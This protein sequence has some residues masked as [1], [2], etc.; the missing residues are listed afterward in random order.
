VL[1]PRNRRAATALALISCG[2]VAAGC[3][4]SDE[5]DAAGG[6][7]PV[8]KGQALVQLDTQIAPALEPDSAAGSN[9]GFEQAF[10]NLAEPLLSVPTADKDG[11]L[12]PDFAVDQE[13]FAPG[14]AESYSKDGL[15][16]TFNLRQGVK[17]CAG[18][19]LTSADVVYT[20][21]RAKSVTGTAPNSDFVATTGG[22]F[23][24]KE[25]SKGATAADK[26]LDG[27][28]VADGKYKVIFKQHSENELFP[29]ILTIWS[30][31]PWDSVEMKKHATSAD[32]YSHKYVETTDAPAFGPYCLDT[33][34][35][36]SEMTFSANPG[37]YAG[38]PT[39]SKITYKQVPADA[40]RL[41]GI[42]SGDGD[43]ATNL[44]PAQFE[45]VGK[46]PAAS[47][48]RW[49][50]PAN[51]I[52]LGVNYKY[53]PFNDLEKG[54]LLRQAIA[55]ALPYEQIKNDIYYGRFTKADGLVP[56]DSFG[57]KK[58]S[59]YNTD[60]AKAKALMAE[61]GYPNGEGLPADSK[62][63]QISY[64][65]ER[66]AT[67]Q[68]LANLIQTTLKGI[69]FPSKLNP[70]PAAQQETEEYTGRSLGMWLRDNSRAL[71]PDVGYASLLYFVS[72]DGGGLAPATNYAD[73][74]VDELY[75]KSATTTG[76]GRAEALN[77]IQD[78]VMDELPLIPIGSATSQIAVTKGMTGWR[79]NTYDLVYW[80]SLTTS[81]N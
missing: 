3:G 60:L 74:R 57:Y 51:F 78:I 77:E 40:Q 49:D 23:T 39:Y 2:I 38:E 34:K 14:L 67:L 35:K 62:A 11:V 27:E 4:S 15:T 7:T 63:F 22:I 76:T 46:S 16:W 9:P 21:A 30:L 79:G 25:L 80:N 6:S 24:G 5:S 48:L 66:S 17:S 26:K 13:D 10:V 53:P 52:S 47:V 31:A 73:D 19:E 50:N 12:V 20:F 42:A 44:T 33:W 64:T 18:N 68:P 41:A 58:I 75:T 55:Y 54:K 8:A 65:A 71:V 69:G 72:A 43:I 81:G 32:P 29:K 61:A 28:V 56:S 59:T 37:W 36:G 70:I 1:T 45:Q